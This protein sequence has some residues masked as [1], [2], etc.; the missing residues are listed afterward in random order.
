M[1][2]PAA[3]LLGGVSGALGRLADAV[4]DLV[5]EVVAV[6]GAGR[7]ADP[8]ADRTRRRLEARARRADGRQRTADEA[9]ALATAGHAA[10][11]GPA[12]LLLLEQQ[13]PALVVLV[14]ALAVP[15]GAH[16]IDAF[17]NGSVV[18]KS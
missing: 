14:R 7:A 5:L 9:A 3:G 16:G 1:L 13:P 2:D 11:R 6:V 17:R 10:E 18:G 4:L 12:D 15:L 8:A